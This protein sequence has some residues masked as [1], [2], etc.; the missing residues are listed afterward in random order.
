MEYWNKRMETMPREQLRELQFKRFKNIFTLAYNNSDAYRE[1]YDS[2]GITPDDLK[3]FEDIKRVP[4]ITK[5][6]FSEN[7]NDDTVYGRTLTCN[8][9][10]VVFYHQTSGTT[11]NTGRYPVAA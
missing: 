11:S 8:P 2:H 6:F 3:S 10:D 5:K 1:L 4:I 9:D 7:L